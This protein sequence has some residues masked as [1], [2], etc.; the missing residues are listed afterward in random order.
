MSA[1]VL[2]QRV[3]KA[4]RLSNWEAST[5]TPQQQMYAATD[6]WVC[7]SIYEKLMAIPPITPLPKDMEV[8]VEQPEQKAYAKEHKPRPRHRANYTQHRNRRENREK[9]Q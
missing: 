4:Q 8:R 2:G 6:A 5:L 3:S 7:I 1:I 9:Q